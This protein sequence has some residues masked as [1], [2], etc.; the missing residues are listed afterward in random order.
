VQ[1]GSTAFFSE[2]EIDQLFSVITSTRDRAIFRLAYHRGLRASEIGRLQ[3][4]DYDPR[5]DRLTLHR[6][7]GSNGGQ[8]RLARRVDRGCAGSSWAPEYPE[9]PD[10]RAADERATSLQGRALAGLVKVQWFLQWFYRARHCHTPI[11]L[12]LSR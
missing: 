3:V 4:S 12:V 7:K 6:V 5:A 9:H 1:R 2:A 8:Y 11:L 10:L